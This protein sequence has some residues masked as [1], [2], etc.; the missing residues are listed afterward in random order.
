M[1]EFRAP[2]VCPARTVPRSS[3]RSCC[4]ARSPGRSSGRVL[5]REAELSFGTAELTLNMGFVVGRVRLLRFMHRVAEAGLVPGVLAALAAPPLRGRS[6]DRLLVRL[7]EPVTAAGMALF[8]MSWET[9]GL[10]SRPR[11]VADL[12]LTLRAGGAGQTF[13]G[14]GGTVWH[15]GDTGTARRAVVARAED[16][17]SW[18]AEVLN[19]ARTV[20]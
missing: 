3:A 6:C 14:L 11:T 19:R 12:R 9:D 17:L 7:A 10:D 2:G 4:C 20:G 13:I 15:P 8:A 5:K 1:A 18:L 16:W